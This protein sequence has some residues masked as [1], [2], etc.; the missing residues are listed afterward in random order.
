MI[1]PYCDKQTVWTENKAI[2]GI[3]Y[4]KS[5][6]CYF[7]KPCN[8]YVGCHNNTR[9]PLG[10]MANAELREWR[11]KAHKVFDPLWKT[12]KMSR[13]K[14]YGK[15]NNHFKRSIHIGESDIV[16]C[17]QII[18]LPTATVSANIETVSVDNV[19]AKGEGSI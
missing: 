13:N 19:E 11:K 1:C 18:E 5:Y 8:A 17:K 7:C 12:G 6:M 14:A 9:K 10:T 2:Y 16:T 4:G 15:L 3:N